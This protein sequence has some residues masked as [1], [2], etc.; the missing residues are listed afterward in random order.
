MLPL[1]T[2][3]GEDQPFFG[4]LLDPILEKAMGE[5]VVFEKVAAE[6]ARSVRKAMPQGPYFIGGWCN[7]GILAF[8]VARQLRA[9]GEEVPLLIMGH[10]INPAAFAAITRKQ[11]LISKARYHAAT[12]WRLPLAERLHYAVARW[13]GTLENLGVSEPDLPQDRYHQLRTALEDAAY[14]YRPGTYDGDVAL[15]QPIDRIHVLDTRPGWAQVVNGRLAAYDVP[16]DHGT[17][18]DP[19]NVTTFATLLRPELERATTPVPHRAAR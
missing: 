6:V 4:L 15:F 5:G 7:T 17:M 3:L 9:M 16:G 14:P 19:P 2:E 18:R 1:A 10:A 8:E 12:W 13:R 11:M